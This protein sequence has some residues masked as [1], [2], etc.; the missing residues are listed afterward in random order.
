MHPLTGNLAEQLRQCTEDEFS[1]LNRRY[2]VV[3]SVDDL[4]GWH[5][6]AASQTK[7]GVY[8][9]EISRGPTALNHAYQYR[10]GY[11]SQAI[12][13]TAIELGF[14]SKPNGYTLP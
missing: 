1:R 13:T 10:H 2:G 14:L 9:I 11:A 7:P 6:V 3:E 4:R 5:L 12:I 8:R